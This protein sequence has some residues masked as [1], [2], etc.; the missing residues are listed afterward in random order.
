MIWFGCSDAHRIPPSLAVH[1]NVQ[2]MLTSNRNRRRPKP[3]DSALRS[4][5]IHHRVVFQH[6]PCTV[7]AKSA[8]SV[9]TSSAG[10]KA[11]HMQR[12]DTAIGQLRRHAGL[13]RIIAPAHPWIVRIVA[14]A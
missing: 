1:L 3:P 9:S 14:L 8:D 6:A 2:P 10:D 7:D 13:R 4:A 12:V 5:E 11:G